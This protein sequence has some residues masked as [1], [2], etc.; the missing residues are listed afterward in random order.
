M[1]Q[2]SL[3]WFTN[4]FIKSIDDSEASDDLAKRLHNLNVHFTY[5]L[6]RNVCRSLFEKDKLLFSFLLCTNILKARGEVDGEEW[7]FLLTGGVGLTN[8][9]KSPAP[10]VPTKSWDELCRLADIGRFAGLR[11]D[12]ASEVTA[13]KSVYDAAAPQDMEFPGKA[14]TYTQLQRM[15]VLRC[16]R[17]DK[18]VPAVQAFVSKEMGQKFIEPPPFDLPGAFADSNSCA[19]LIFVLSP[20]GDPTAALLK[21]A[22]DSGFGSSMEM[23]SLGQGQG[24]IAM[25]LIERGLAEGTWVVLQNCHLAVSWMNT[26]EKICEELN[27]ETTHPNFR[28]WLTSYPSATFPVAVLQNGVKMTNEPPQGLRNNVLRTYL[29]DPVSDMEFFDGCQQ[30]APFRKLIFGVAFVHAL[31]QERRNFGALGWNIPYEFNDTD[32]SISVKQINMFLNQYENVD[33]DAIR[34]LIG[35]CNYGGRVTDDWDRRCLVSILERVLIVDMVNVDNYSLSPSGT[36]LAPPH[37]EYDGYLDFIRALPLVPQPEVFGMHENADI[38]KDQKATNDLLLSILGT[39]GVGG[40]G[41]GTGGKSDDEKLTE[42]ARDMISKLPGN[43]DTAAALRKYPTS[44]SESMN[45][46]LVQ[47]MGRFNRLTSVVR[48]S[49]VNIQK[50]V[51]GLVVM[52]KELE[53]VGQAMLSGKIPE[54]WLKKSYPSLKP[55]G[56]YV[57]DLLMRLKFLQDWYDGGAPPVFWVSGFYFTQAFLTGV[58]Q[59]FARKYKIPIDLL[60]YDFEVLE[61]KQYETPPDDGAYING[62]FLD[63][64]RWDGEAGLLGEQVYNTH[65]LPSYALSRAP[66]PLAVTRL[67]LI[68]LGCTLPLGA[69]QPSL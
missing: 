29:L 47:E 20:G 3:P 7:M 60:G 41:G 52:S 6:Y 21:F 24:P 19:P 63:G 17:P 46:V 36:Y 62:L 57:N 44:Y 28:L 65:I 32:F 55:L 39:Q 50:A 43:F 34:Y 33:Y 9:H 66:P 59:N 23:L 42:I 27:P 67:R 56:G 40:G 2:Y 25:R 22:D 54:M 64:A 5:S 61:L 13:W 69:T 18:V 38:T 14:K 37:V 31:V 51:K 53:G 16:L 35:Q 10:W 49:L 15:I 48:S 30:A 58:Q 12:F 4:L 26:L 45:T 1:Y 68:L 8:P 11:E